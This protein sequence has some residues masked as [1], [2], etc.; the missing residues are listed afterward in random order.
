MAKDMS[1]PITCEVCPHH[2]F[3][4]ENDVETSLGDKK[5][6]VRPCLSTEED[7]NYLLE[8]L[9]EFID[10]IGSDHAPHTIEEKKSEKGNNS[11]LLKMSQNLIKH[12]STNFLNFGTK[13]HQSHYL[14]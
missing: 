14:F 3:L 4:S 12:I 13:S 11:I 7:R 5:G 9:A 10:T 1:H 6:Q 2:L 8:N